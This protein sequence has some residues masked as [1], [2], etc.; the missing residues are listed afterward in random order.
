MIICRT[1]SA[2]ITGGLSNSLAGS[3]T[4]R[5]GS[6]RTPYGVCTELPV[7]DRHHDVLLLLNRSSRYVLPSI[8]LRVL[9][10][11]ASVLSITDGSSR[12][13]G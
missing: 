8:P 9:V 5:L 4:N 6:A 7:L 2:S 11:I 13:W 3:D 12:T 10:C 1:V